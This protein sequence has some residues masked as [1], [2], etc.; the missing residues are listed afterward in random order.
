MSKI[1]PCIYGI[2]GN[3]FSLT[4]FILKLVYTW[5]IPKK[6]ARKS[7]EQNDI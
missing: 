6:Y 5:N 2:S 7:I 1:E 4:L 3:F